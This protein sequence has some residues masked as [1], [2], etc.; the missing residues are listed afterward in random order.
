MSATFTQEEINLREVASEV[1]GLS[2]KVAENAQALLPMKAYAGRNLIING[3]FSVWQRGDSITT[4]NGYGADRFKISYAS[5]GLDVTASKQSEYSTEFG[6]LNYTRLTSDT[7]NTVTINC[8]WRTI[9]EAPTDTFKNKTV[10][11]SCLVRATGDATKISRV[12][13]LNTI[14]NE[15]VPISNVWQ[16]LKFTML[17]SGGHA[18]NPYAFRF[19]PQYDV[20]VGIDIAQCQFELGSEATE[21]EHVD[22]AT[23]LA[24]C[25]R[26]FQK[27]YSDGNAIGS[28][29]AIGAFTYRAQTG[30]SMYYGGSVTFGTT[31]RAPPTVVPYSLEGLASN[32]TLAG[33]SHPATASVGDRSFFVQSVDMIVGAVNNLCYFHW[34]A[35]AEL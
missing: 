26:Y 11:F 8:N 30:V 28:A 23:Q 29:S 32:L 24:R 20:N 19:I 17:L 33:V 6:L 4:N 2:N 35:D 34:T 3:D 7:P 13:L 12:A 15:D 10:T 5:G 9:L 1:C 18:E 25:Q 14:V 27:S 31:M 16:R 22:P 21:F